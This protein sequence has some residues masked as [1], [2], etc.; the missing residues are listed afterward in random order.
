MIKIKLAG[1]VFGIDN[2]YTYLEQICHNYLTEEIAEKIFCVSEEEMQ[3]ENSSDGNWTNSYLESLSIY[4][5]I[6]EYLLDFDILLF[7]CSAL[8][9]DEKAYLFTA[10]SGTG[11]ST[12]AR[13]WCERYGDLVTMINDDKPFL[14]LKD[15]TVTVYG[16]PY[17]GKDNIQT[18]TSARVAGIVVL[19]QAKQNEIHRLTIKESYP[20]LLNQTYRCKYPD[21]LLHTLNL[22]RKLCNLPVFSLGCTISE[23]AVE[24]AWSTLRMI[25]EG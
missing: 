1:H 22:V 17:A 10:P 3:A 8:M 13:L 12:H 21:K 9:I 20:I 19:H 6:T 23:E 5:K 24:L 15:N 14:M 25:E 16:T 2:H 18:N 7:H 4:R 11:K